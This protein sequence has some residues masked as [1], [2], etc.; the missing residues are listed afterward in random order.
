[1]PKFPEKKV[2]W[3]FKEAIL[4]TGSV[5]ANE[6]RKDQMDPKVENEGSP[7]DHGSNWG[8]SL[9]V[10]SVQEMVRDDPESV[11]ERYIQ[12]HKDKPVVPDIQP[13][14]FDIPIIDFSLL[15]KGEEDEIRKLDL[16]CKEWGFFQVNLANELICYSFV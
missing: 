4:S 8:K 14:S 7:E 2:S 6:S 11:P 15:A 13:A 9:P 5:E 10:P 1:M 3:T 16:A 12:E